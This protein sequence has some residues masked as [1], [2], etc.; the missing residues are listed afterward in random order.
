MSAL[1]ERA[2]GANPAG[3][4]LLAL[5]GVTKSWGQQRVLD[6]VD[7]I[8][9]PG[10]VS[11]VVGSNGTGKTTLLR[12]ATGIILPDAGVVRFRGNDIERERQTYRGAV[13]FL[14]AG[15]RGLYA[16]LTVEQNLDFWAGLS[17][18]AKRRRRTRI[19][20]ILARFEL[21]P[22]AGRRVD[23]LSL[24]QRQRVRLA[25]TFLSEP[26]VVILDEPRTSLDERGSSILEEAVGGLLANGGAVVWASPEVESSIANEVWA[27][28]HG[29]LEAR[30]GE[31][32]TERAQTVT[33]G[34]S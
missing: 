5:E 30:I 22:L 17:G 4:P 18:F 29:R 3:G 16:R 12:I 9:Q 27:L 23:R 26:D 28:E 31:A 19:G 11:Q 25:M 14:S 24:G 6:A 15:D 10:R 7:L 1:I 34:A 33:A 13:G 8:V 20:E 2:G 21:D 32:G